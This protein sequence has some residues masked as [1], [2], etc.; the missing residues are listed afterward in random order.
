MSFNNQPFWMGKSSGNLNDG[1]DM[2]YDNSSRIESKRT[3]QWFMDS[4]EVDLVPNKKQAVE[5]PNSLSSGMLNSNISSWGNSLTG[6]FTAQLFDPAAASMNFE[7]T[8]IFPLNIDNKLS[9]EEKDIL[10]PFGGDASFGLSMSTTLEDSQ[11]VFNHDGIRKVKVNEVKESEN[12]M[13][14]PTNNPY[15]GGV[16]NT[17]SNTH[18]FKEGD[19][20]ISTSLTYNKGD[21]NVILVDG[22]FDRT[23]NNLMS[24]SQSYNEGDGNLS[25]PST[26]K[27]IGNH[28]FNKV[29]DGTISMG[30][31]YHQR[32]NDMPFVAHSYNK[33]G[34]TIISFGGCDDGDNDVTPADLFVS[35]YGL[36]M[37]QAPLCMS[38]MSQVANEKELV[39]SSTKLLS[40]TAQTSASETENVTKTKEEMKMCKKATSNNFPSNV[41]SLLSTGMLDGVSVKYKAWSREKELRAVIK[42]AGYLCSCPSCSFSKVINAFEF[43]RHAGCKTK[44][45]N[46]H[47][48]FENGKTIYGV[49]QELRSTP[50]NM[51]F[52]VIQTI[53]GSP[54]NQK[55]FRIWKESFLAAARELQR[56]CGKDEV[57]QLL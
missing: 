20:S 38:H 49:V 1:D 39:R 47:I 56:I 14:A 22:V 57:K 41:R 43:E 27:D 25:I 2:T 21:D 44:H 48:Y 31:T 51:L 50:P 55:S 24:M 19:H 16:S 11:L 5:A 28:L 37:G 3:N 10:D 33:G 52:E 42:G 54:I 35:D 23:N 9:A 15:D 29:E 4:P 40:I 45:P 7:D 6:H 30:H 26:Y 32:G 8:N 18:A 53:T 46:N 36:F 17:V 34:S 12:F 13:S